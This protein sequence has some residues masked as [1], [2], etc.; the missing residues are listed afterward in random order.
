MSYTEEQIQQ[1]IAVLNSAGDDW[2]QI[3]KA[4]PTVRSYDDARGTARA[5]IELDAPRLS[6]KEAGCHEPYAILYRVEATPYEHEDGDGEHPASWFP[7]G[8]SNAGRARL[9]RQITSTGVE[10]KE[11]EQ[12]VDKYE[13]RYRVLEA[14]IQQGACNSTEVENAIRVGD[15]TELDALP[16]LMDLEGRCIEHV[17]NLDKWR[18]LGTH[19]DA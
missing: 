17:D 18:V 3:A 8:W 12:P 16:V 11:E 10:I 5:F 7:V 9:G 19:P 15:G 2:K 6:N 1:T 4:L 13:A 14:L